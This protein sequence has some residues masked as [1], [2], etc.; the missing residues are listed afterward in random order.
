MRRK[1]SSTCLASVEICEA[2]RF[3]G[4]LEERENA[5]APEDLTWP[6]GLQGGYGFG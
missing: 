6:D 2:V 4:T 1:A 3:A 5:L